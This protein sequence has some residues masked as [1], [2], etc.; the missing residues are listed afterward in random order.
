MEKSKSFEKILTNVNI[1]RYIIISKVK[2]GDYSTNKQV[3]SFYRDLLNIVFDWKLEKSEKINNPGIDLACEANKVGVQV[4]SQCGSKKIKKTLG[5]FDKH[6]DGKL[7]RVII[8]NITSKSKHSKEFQS[9]VPF[10]KSKDI[11]DVDDLLFEIEKLET[12][13]IKLIEEFI[14]SEIPYYIGKITSEKDILRN[15]L[16]FKNIEAKMCDRFLDINPDTSELDKFIIKV[17]NLHT[18]LLS[19]S[20]KQRQGFFAFL[21]KCEINDFELAAS[22]WSDILLSSF[23]FQEYEL[24]GLLIVLEEKNLLYSDEDE[25][26]PKIKLNDKY[27][28]FNILE[29]IKNPD[30]LHDFICNVNFS[31]LDK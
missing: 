6:Y 29:L 15:R 18:K 8:F 31:K 12:S 9:T 5:L 26:S 16:D 10:D 1:L 4:T 21:M 19:I 25:F 27:F 14:I 3:E 30:D 11:I 20:K 22:T 17:K 13:K 24:N 2:Q 23:D 28:F 7:N